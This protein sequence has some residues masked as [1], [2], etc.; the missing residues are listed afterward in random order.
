MTLAA[1]CF[2]FFGFRGCQ[3]NVQYKGWYTDRIF[4]HVYVDGISVGGACRINCSLGGKPWA[5][6]CFSESL[7]VKGWT[8]PFWSFF[9]LGQPAQVHFSHTTDNDAKLG[10]L[11]FVSVDGIRGI[12]VFRN[13]MHANEDFLSWTCYYAG[14]VLNLWERIRRFSIYLLWYGMLLMRWY[15]RRKSK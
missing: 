8:L 14:G 12:S 3:C 10:Q 2:L 13:G 6:R 4:I 11:R 15:R 9:F 1:D 5:A 7:F